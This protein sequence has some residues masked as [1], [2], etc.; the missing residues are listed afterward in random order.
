MIGVYDISVDFPLTD[1][2]PLEASSLVLLKRMGGIDTARVILPVRRDVLDSVVG[3]GSPIHVR[4]RAGSRTDS[5]HGYVYSY[6]PGTVEYSDRTVLIV[7]GAAYPMFS[8]RGRTFYR[9]GIHSIAEEICDDY[10]FQL[11]VEPHPIVQEQILQRDESDWGLLSR[12]ADEW[13]YVLSM[14]GVTVVFRPLDHVLRESFRRITYEKIAP[15]LSMFSMD[16]SLVEFEPTWQTAGSSPSAVTKGGGVDPAS[17]SGIQWS[18]SGRETMFSNVQVGRD[19][20]SELEGRLVGLSESVRARFPYRA[21]ALFIEPIGKKPL[22]VYRIE[23]NKKVSNWVVLSVK[24]V[25]S[26]DSFHGD[27]V[28]GSYGSNEFSESNVGLDVATILNANK[29]AARP[30]PY[31]MDTRPIMKGIGANADIEDQRWRARV[32]TVLV[33][34]GA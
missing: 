13:G 7:V 26:K 6:R 31:L 32:R 29:Y 10:G 24:Y 18:S 8:E 28:L 19:V 9:M 22:D 33:G 2:D 5:M 21:K 14:E 12:L 15:E 11:E 23:D 1:L 30:E 25:V 34:E 16:R 27:M 17:G 20:A 4:W 3:A